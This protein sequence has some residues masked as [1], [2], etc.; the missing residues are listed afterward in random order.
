MDHNDL[1]SLVEKNNKH[2]S[3]VR[4]S[5]LLGISRAS[6][7]Y[8]PTAISEQD[9]HI[10]DLID[11]IY[12]D[13]P[14]YGNRRMKAEL[15]KT[16]NIEVGRDHVRTLMRVMGLEAIYPKP[17]LSNPCKD[18]K[19]YPYLLRNLKITKPNQVW[20]T[21][22]TYVKLETGWAYLIAIIDWFS[23]YVI[24]WELSNTLEIDFCLDCL[25]QALNNNKQKPS[26]FNTDQ[27][28]QFTSSKFTNILE[29]NQINISMDGR[30]RCLDNIF[31]ERLWRTV[32]QEDIYLKSYS[33]IRET[34]TGLNQYFSFYNNQ[35]R[36]QSLKY[37]T[38][39]SVYC[40]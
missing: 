10:M 13:C 3:L 15:N 14:Y 33:D 35:R 21:D 34:R 30:G 8:Q 29:Q 18:H 19:K 32:K 31:V 38:P 4:Q 22:I 5:E 2:I 12:T 20:S 17:N 28:S 24:N 25:N 1:R 16:H 6:M 26:I 36:H 9:K 39:A 23:R 27:G 37:E 40:K 11:A 7:Y